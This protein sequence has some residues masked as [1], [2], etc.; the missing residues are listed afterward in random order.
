MI[1]SEDKIAVERCI[2]CTAHGPGDV[3]P[4][5]CLEETCKRFQPGPVLT[6]KET[7]NWIKK[8]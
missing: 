2:A 3:F 5:P 8:F 7:I 4:G 6:I 1:T